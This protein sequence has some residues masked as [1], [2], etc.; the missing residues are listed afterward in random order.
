M[1][2]F[3]IIGP[4]MVGPSSS[5]TAGVVRIGNFVY[6]LFGTTPKEVKITFYGSFADTYKGHGSDRAIVAGLL[7]YDTDDSRIIDALDIA[8]NEGYRFDITTSSNNMPHPNTVM[9]E[10]YDTRGNHHRIIAESIGGSN[11]R[12]VKIN[13]IDVDLDG[14]CD[15]LITSHFDKP[16]VVSN[17]SHILYAEKINI[18]GMKV[19]S[20]KKGEAIMMVEIDNTPSDKALE[21][22]NEVENINTVQY[23]K[24]IK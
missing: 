17:V 10:A 1:N 20:T 21:L 3:D 23:V 13:E 15:A 4:V 14:S 2:I 11:I 5:H 7:G 9:I 24:K 12:I 19:F 18:V 6:K 22:I 16:G 8:V